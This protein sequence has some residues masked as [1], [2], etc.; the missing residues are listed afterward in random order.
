MSRTPSAPA[1]RFHPKVARRGPDECW[2]W[3]GAVNKFTGYG[4]F[5]NGKSMIGA[6]RMAY[7]V[8]VGPIPPRMTID[9]VCN[10]RTCVNPAHLRVCTTYENTQAAKE[11]R[12][13]CRA[14]H[15]LID[16]TYTDQTGASR[17]RAC[18]TARH[19]EYVA[20]L[21]AGTQTVGPYRA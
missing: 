21:A 16:H 17:C 6:H 7:E 13:A 11:R 2:Q 12:T 10:V 15:P 1:D 18:N 19:R 4:A 5:Y 20:R 14:G 9:H 8:H 3:L